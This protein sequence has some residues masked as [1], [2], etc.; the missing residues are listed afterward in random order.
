MAYIIPLDSL[1]GLLI[2]DGGAEKCEMNMMQ[3]DPET[4][5]CTDML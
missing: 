5:T 2:D 4:S 1:Y 3:G